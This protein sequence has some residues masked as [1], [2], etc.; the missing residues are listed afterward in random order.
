[1]RTP[2]SVYGVE[3]SV[4]GFAPLTEVGAQHLIKLRKLMEIKFLEGNVRDAA[5][6]PLLELPLLRS[7]WIRNCAL[8]GQFLKCSEVLPTVTE[9][10]LSYCR[11]SE[12]PFQ[13]LKRFPNLQVLL[14]ESLQDTGRNLNQ[15]ASAPNLRVV[16]FHSSRVSDSQGLL[17][18][19]ELLA[20]K[21]SI[22]MHR[23]LSAMSMFER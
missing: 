2:Q 4:L 5:L 9:I 10:D 11:F 15:L 7:F 19:R 8:S 6:A 18:W 22:F 1:M 17:N 3:R 21:P 20:W 16:S 12:D 13:Y 14:F 23:D